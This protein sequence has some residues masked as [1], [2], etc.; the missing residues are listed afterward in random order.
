MNI[1]GKVQAA[2]DW[3]LQE[4]WFWYVSTGATL[5]GLLFIQILWFNGT[6]TLRDH[7][8]YTKQIIQLNDEYYRVQAAAK[9]GSNDS[10][11][12]LLAPIQ[13]KRDLVSPQIESA[14]LALN[15]FNK[16]WLWSYIP[17]SYDSAGASEHADIRVASSITQVLGLYILPL[18]YGLLG[19]LLSIV[20]FLRSDDSNEAIRKLRP[21]ARV[22]TG[23]VAGPMIG[24]LISPE[25]L[26]SLAFQATPFVLAFIGGY[27]TDVFFALI[28]RFLSSFRSNISKPDSSG[29]ASDKKDAGGAGDVAAGNR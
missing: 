17:G 8:D 20:Q 2:S 27:A 19:A 25:F 16:H 28:D 26:N 5:F 10:A 12:D 18:F 21:G 7:Q 22:V 1:I 11:A 13:K 9:G 15:S 3:A 23:S 24:M 4:K 6:T 29:G 14:S